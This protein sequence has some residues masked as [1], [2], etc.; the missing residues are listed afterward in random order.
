MTPGQR[1]QFSEFIRQLVLAASSMSLYSPEHRTTIDR[2]S[3][4]LSCLTEAL[5]GDDSVTAMVLGSEL[6]L[7]GTP[8]DRDPQL[9]RV[10]RELRSY[11]IGHITFQRGITYDELVLLLRII[12]RQAER[13]PGST[14]HLSFGSLETEQRLLN[15]DDQPPIPTYSAIPPQLLQR[16]ANAFTACADGEQLD[17]D[18]IMTL[19]SGFVT[20]FRSEANPLLALVPLREMDEYTFTHSLDVCI[21]N[22]VQGM[23]LGLDGQELHDI[24][25]A[26]LLHDVGKLRIPKHVLTK[27]GGLSE[28]EWEYMRQHAVRG[29]EYLLNTPGVPRVAILTAF[30]HHMKCDHTGYPQVAPEWRINL[31]SLL[32]MISDTFDAVR[33][34]RVYQDAMDFP[35]AA[36]IMLNLA[37]SGLH[38]ALTL[39]FLEL[40]RELGEGVVSGM[41]RSRSAPASAAG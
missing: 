34:K 1:N 38:R 40:L 30:E 18:A 8:L 9:E 3:R 28:E 27:S 33:T 26:G 10:L 15:Q 37:G 22:L 7:D 16:V 25:I 21:L 13:N 14:P 23:S 17:L 31:C 29:A 12:T 36:G 11:G 24:G 35:K 19:V 20:A 5:A 41:L 39:N 2:T 32:T 4:A 6:F